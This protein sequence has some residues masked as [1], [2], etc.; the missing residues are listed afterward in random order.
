MK[1]DI[2]FL[3]IETT[4]LDADRGEVITAVLLGSGSSNYQYPDG[5]KWTERKMLKRLF[6]SMRQ[7]DRIVTYYG[8]GFDVPFLR[9]RALKLGLEFPKK[10]YHTDLYY[11]VR[12]KMK[13]HRNSLQAATR[14]LGIDGKNGF[15]ISVW[16]KARDGDTKAIAKI[17]DHNIRDV[18]ILERL[19]K[20]L[21]PY[22][23][24]T[25]RMI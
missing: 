8:T 10:V 9:S 12:S 14:F 16:N 20:R 18:K 7:Y 1:Y 5:K 11:V 22:F 25:K 17:L 24:D 23:K 2:G 21:R 15:D 3:D 4:D 6:A 19:Y 13:L